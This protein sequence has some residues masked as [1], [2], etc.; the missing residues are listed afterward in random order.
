MDLKKTNY[1]D[2]RKMAA[3]KRWTVQETGQGL[4]AMTGYAYLGDEEKTALFSGADL[5]ARIRQASAEKPRETELYLRL[6]DRAGEVYS[7]EYKA[8]IDDAEPWVTALAEQSAD[9]RGTRLHD[10]A[11]ETLADARET[12]DE[13]QQELADAKQKLEDAKQTLADAEQDVLDGEQKLADAKEEADRELADAYKE[14]QVAI[15]VGKVF[16][17]TENRHNFGGDG[18]VKT[19]SA[20]NAVSL[21]AEAD[22]DFAEG[23]VV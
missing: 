6:T 7:D 13:K 2:P 18:D 14:A 20:G 15:E 12:L 8:R 3:R 9:D 21:A 4:I 1:F 19:V 23:A 5:D 17:Q 16:G 22:A 10:D 11:A